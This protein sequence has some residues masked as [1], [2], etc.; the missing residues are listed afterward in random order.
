MLPE[1]MAVFLLLKNHA[2]QAITMDIG[3]VFALPR[4]GEH[5]VGYNDQGREDGVLELP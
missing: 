2:A 4:K 3:V 1:Q 5:D